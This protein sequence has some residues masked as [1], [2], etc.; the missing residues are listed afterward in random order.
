MSSNT[1]PTLERAASAEI[2][3]HQLGRLRALLTFLKEESGNTFYQEKL[4]GTDPARLLEFKD[5]AALPFTLKSELVGQQN[6]FPPYGHNLSYP[7]SHYT[8]LHQTSGTTGRPLKVLDTNESWDWWARCW[9]EVYRAAGVTEDDQVFLAF[10]FGPFIGFWA[11]YTGAEKL[12]ALVIPGGGM[13]TEQ[14][15]AA[16]IEQGAT[17]ICC[18]PSYALHMAEVAE[19]KGINLAD[20]K[21]RVLI[22]AGEPGA[23]IPVVR[24][25]IEQAWGATVYDH[26]GASEIGAFGFSCSAQTGLHLNE[27]EFIAEVLKPETNEPVPIGETGELV[28]TNLGRWGYPVIRYRTSD[29]VRI[30]KAPCECG[31]SYKLLEGGVI[32]R[33]DN[34]IIVRGINIYPSS[35]EAIV[36]ELVPTNEFRMIFSQVDGMDELE[37][38]VEL[39]Q[40]ESEKLEKLRA[41]FRQRLALRVPVRSVEPGTLPRFQL[42]ARRIVDNR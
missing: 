2:E 20:S 8:K 9:L 32:G 33:T 11:A 13:D 4:A 41:L 36:R 30:A 1:E 22:H 14:R 35:V 37:V 23:S 21:V 19:Q 26:S 7:L 28:L 34:M 31:R 42:K 15:L 10:S 39:A 29:V 27:S 17:V 18:T 6:E 25:R 12:G 38:E 24:R 5:I 40:D 16:I 3:Q